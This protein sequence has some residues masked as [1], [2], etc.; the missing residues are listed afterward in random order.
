MLLS[1]SRKNCLIS[2]L[3]SKSRFFRNFSDK[4]VSSLKM[5]VRSQIN[6]G[7]GFSISISTGGGGSMEVEMGGGCREEGERCREE[8][9]R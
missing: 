1:S 9:G 8:L 4:A 6:T 5:V 3:R 7:K 2:F